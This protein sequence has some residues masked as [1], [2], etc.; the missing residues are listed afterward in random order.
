MSTSFDPTKLNT[1]R[2]AGQSQQSQRPRAERL[3][4]VVKNY[5]TPPDG[6]HYAV[7]HRVEAPNELI[8]VRLNTV[9]E[10]VADWPTKADE[11][12]VREQYVTGDKHRDTIADKAKANVPLI[13]FDEAYAIGRSEDGVVEYRAHWPKV[14]STSP[15]AEAMVGFGHIR[16]RDSTEGGEGGTRTKTQAYVELLRSSAKLS[17]DN[18][19]AVLSHALSIKD[20]QGRARDPIAIIRVFHDG[21]QVAAPRLYPERV[22]TKKFDQALGGYKEVNTKADA[23]VTL[24]KLMEGGK[25]F[26]AFDTEYRDVIRAV[27]SGVKGLP[28]PEFFA[29]NPAAKERARHYYFGAAQGAL[30]VEVV[31]AE[32]ID[33][34]ADSRKT[35]LAEAGKSHLAAYTIE[36]QDGDNIKRTPGYASTVVA[37]HRYP[38]GEPYAVFASPVEMWAKKG[39]EKLADM[40]ADW[41]PP[42][43]LGLAATNEAAPLAA[44]VGGGSVEREPALSGADD[45]TDLS[46]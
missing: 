1:T 5:E 38:D 23:D 13:S 10:R 9:A 44:E 28:E 32:K 16:L 31:A 37:V 14:M 39:M 17:K 30:S 40:P 11:A 15:E 34:G 20:D 3:F 22:A 12:K 21:K 18:A 45:D 42:T 4:L 43:D 7:G 8:R 26:S 6:F 29:E 33:F 19:D 24:S 36:E 2:G 35:Y 27:V 41:L 25:G 46:M